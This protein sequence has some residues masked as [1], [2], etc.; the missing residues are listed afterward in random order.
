MTRTRKVTA[1]LAAVCLALTLG[2]P[3]LADAAPA[4]SA[5]TAAYGVTLSAAPEDFRTDLADGAATLA[6]R[7]YQVASGDEYGQYTLAAGFEALAE[8]DAWNGGALNGQR[9]SDLVALR[10]AA[11][12]V[13][14]VEEDEPEAGEEPEGP[15]EPEE[16]A[17]AIEPIFE[18]ELLVVGG[19]LAL[20]ER[21][22]YLVV[23]T[24]TAKTRLWEYTFSPILLPVPAVDEG[25][26]LYDVPVTMKPERESRLTDFVIE[27]QLDTYN[28]DLGPTTFVFEVT[29]TVDGAQVYSNVVT[30]TFSSGG[31]ETATVE[32][33]P[34]GADVTVREVYSGASYE[35]KDPIELTINDLPLP[36]EDGTL[37]RVGFENDYTGGTSSD[38][39]V[40]NVF[41]FNGTGWAYVQSEEVTG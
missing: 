4:E 21:G 16:P 29:A 14:G 2:A 32:G 18:G 36:A 24:D 38:A 3:A 17:P 9:D 19:H 12:T 8:L 27:K 31:L 39:G 11:L 35:A 15:A 30:L 22:L 23:P 28:A 25:A 40:E 20:A 7:V 13:L 1:M 6:V 34:V 26:W 41:V 33:I 10:E 37:A 5:E